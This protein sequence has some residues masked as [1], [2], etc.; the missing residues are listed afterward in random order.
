[1]K[2]LLV[3]C[4]IFL[5]FIQCNLK[6]Y[7]KEYNE[8]IYKVIPIVETKTD[9]EILRAII[10]QN[11]DV[12]YDFL[13]Q[14]DY[15]EP[16]SYSITAK[17]K[18]DDAFFFYSCPKTY[19]DDI[20]DLEANVKKSPIDS[21]MRISRKKYS[22]PENF[23]FELV[24]SVNPNASSVEII[25]SK[26]FSKEL[27]D[28]LSDEIMRKAIEM[29]EELKTDRKSSMVTVSN[30]L[31]E[32]YAALYSF[33]IGNKT[34][35][36]MFITM[37]ISM[38]INFTHK[39]GLD[40]YKTVTK[41]LWTNTGL[42]S[43]RTLAE[44]YDKYYDDFMVFAANSSPNQKA[45]YALKM[46]KRQMEIELSPSYYDY[47]TG[48]R[49]RNMPS[50][51]FRR[52]YSGGMADYSSEYDLQRPIISNASWLINTIEPQSVFSYRNISSVYKQKFYVP[53][54]YKYFYYNPI[55]HIITIN[56]NNQKPQ[57]GGMSLKREK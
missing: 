23:I 8:R 47:N 35:K 7:A 14:K 21:V 48:S 43:F 19:V 56:K 28:Y 36:Q 44:N 41:K 17:S 51:L 38:D 31:A 30:A 25:S 16:L 34:Y 18:D 22:S 2:K 5:A 37:F 3:F 46:T 9:S 4:F 49:L 13:W 53:G 29:Q 1:M 42:Y 27:K 45:A 32:P 6:S 33:K 24:H 40:N 11:F 10:P 50:E 15:E 26:N 39:N 52:Y 55:K 20:S 12:N 54:K 57:S